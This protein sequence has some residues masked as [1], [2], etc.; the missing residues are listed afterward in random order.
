[1]SSYFFNKYQ[2]KILKV[3][4]D[5]TFR[6]NLSTIHHKLQRSS[7]KTRNSSSPNNK[8]TKTDKLFI[9]STI[10]KLLLVMQITWRSSRV[11]ITVCQH[12]KFPADVLFKLLYI[13]ILSYRENRKKS[14]FIV[15]INFLSC[16][17][18]QEMFYIS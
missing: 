7:R 10:C 9:S 6:P 2:L 16:F 14:K 4:Y 12:K 3:L 8:Q 11:H 17:S 5:M 15:F 18:T 13:S 1:M